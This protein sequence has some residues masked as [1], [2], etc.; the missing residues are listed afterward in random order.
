VR[1]DAFALPGGRLLT[2]REFTEHREGGVL[3]HGALTIS[4]DG[5]RI[6]DDSWAWGPAGVP[7]YWDLRRWLRGDSWQAEDAVRLPQRLYLWDAP[8]CRVGDDHLV[9]WGIGDD[10]LEMLPGAVLVPV[11]PGG[12]EM[13]F[14]GVPRG[15]LHSDGRLLYVVGE[16]GLTVWDPFAGER[17]AE[18][19]G[20]R[21]AGYNPFTDEFLVRAGPG[22]T[23]RVRLMITD[24]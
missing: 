1:V 4:P 22:R 24:S 15:D 9:R 10:D 2:T 16:T 14:A 19:V 12:P 8:V 17:L 20:F 13:S 23:E 3:F 18:L 5:T 6:L 11:G 21:P 7:T